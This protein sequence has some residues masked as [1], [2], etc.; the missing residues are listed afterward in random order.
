MEKLDYTNQGQM[1]SVWKTCQILAKSQIVPEC[2]RGKPEDIYAAKIY[3]DD[4]QVGLLPF[5]HN[6]YMMHGKLGMHS[7][8]LTATVNRSK[9]FATPLL[10]KK[11]KGDNG[12]VDSC[13]AYAKLQSGETVTGSEIT[14]AM[15]KENNWDKNS[16]WKTIRELMFE[17]RAAAFFARVYC[18]EA[19]MG[20]M[21]VEEIEDMSAGKPEEPRTPLFGAK[22]PEEPE[23]QKGALREVLDETTRQESK[24]IND[25]VQGAKKTEAKDPEAEVT[26]DNKPGTT[27]ET[28]ANP[29][30]AILEAL[31]QTHPD[32]MSD[33]GK[34]LL[35]FLKAK[36]KVGQ[37]AKTLSDVSLDVFVLIQDK[38]DGVAKHVAA[39][40]QANAESD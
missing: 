18:P 25:E 35:S 9:I 21:T 13:T 34:W 16:K 4:M 38:P 5:L 8:L 23:T 24:R 40:K 15:V 20:L 1:E 7:K 2:Y 19:T 3:A 26:S 6:T 29:K 10:F 37:A 30:T 36:K 12:V 28:E 32:M 27:G 17:Y 22:P 14:W 39:L 31:R 33:N 11:G